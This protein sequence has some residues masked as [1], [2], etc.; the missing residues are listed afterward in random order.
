MVCWSELINQTQTHQPFSQHQNLINL[1]LE[2]EKSNKQPLMDPM[3][4]SFFL[5][6]NLVPRNHII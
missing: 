1:N 4:L 3:A 6:L 2:A 5:F